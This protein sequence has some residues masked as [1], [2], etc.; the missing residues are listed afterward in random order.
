M[1]VWGIGIA[2][3][4]AAAATDVYI[5]Y[6]HFDADIKCAD[7]IGAG[8]CTGGVAL[9]SQPGTFKTDKLPTE[10]I[11]VIVMGARVLF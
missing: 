2:Q 1:K 3:N 4:I 7:A 10:G 11:D 6:R 5:G 8:T 9:G